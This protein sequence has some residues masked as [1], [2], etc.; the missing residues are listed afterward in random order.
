VGIFYSTGGLM[1]LVIV[2]AVVGDLVTQ[3]RRR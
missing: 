3:L 1:L 2:L